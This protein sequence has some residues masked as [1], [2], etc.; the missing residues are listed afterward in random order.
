MLTEKQHLRSVTKTVEKY[1]TVTSTEQGIAKAK[2]CVV[3][4]TG[5]S[6]EITSVPQHYITLVERGAM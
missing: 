4:N 3:H 1:I 2:T 6:V 5:G